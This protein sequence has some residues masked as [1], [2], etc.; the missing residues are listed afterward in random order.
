MKRL[1]VITTAI[2]V[3]VFIVMVILGV[4]GIWFGDSRYGG[5]AVLAG[6]VTFV[7]GA[8]SSFAWIGVNQ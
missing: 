5:L 6:L 3:I 8:A 2:A 7:A 4:L 1:A